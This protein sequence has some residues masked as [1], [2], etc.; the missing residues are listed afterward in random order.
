MRFLWKLA[1]V[2]KRNMVKTAFNFGF[3][4]MEIIG[5]CSANVQHEIPRRKS[6]K[7]SK[8]SIKIITDADPLREK[9]FKASLSNSR[10][11][12]SAQMRHAFHGIVTK[13]KSSELCANK[14]SKT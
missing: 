5:K 3:L 2:E 14:K 12:C 13:I 1:K 4:E 11:S 6:L 9:T 7:K 10:G 8:P